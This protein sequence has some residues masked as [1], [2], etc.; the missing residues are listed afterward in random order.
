MTVSTFLIVDTAFCSVWLNSTAL[1][2][3]AATSMN[4]MWARG[5][6]SPVCMARTAGNTTNVSPLVC[7]RP[8]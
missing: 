3:L 1:P 6:M 8:K 4:G 5:N 7:P 2:L